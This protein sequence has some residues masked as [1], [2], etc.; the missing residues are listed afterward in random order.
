ME[1][2][3]KTLFAARASPVARRLSVQAASE[4]LKRIKAEREE[5]GHKLEK[6]IE[7]ALNMQSAE[8]IKS[9]DPDLSKEDKQ[10]AID[11][12]LEKANLML[13]ELETLKPMRKAVKE[14]KEALALA[15]QPAAV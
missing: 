9:G 12:T 14:G 5:K 7:K 11:A 6:A 3:E 15:L 13:R 1:A 4:H 8:Y 10:Q 2:L